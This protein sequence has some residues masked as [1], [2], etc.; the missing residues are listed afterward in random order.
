M[1]SR[2]K[3]LHYSRST[4]SKSHQELH[5]KPSPVLV[6]WPKARGV[7]PQYRE[8]STSDR[9]SSQPKFW[10]FWP[11]DS[12][13]QF[14]RDNCWVWLS[15]NRSSWAPLASAYFWSNQAIYSI[16]VLF[17]WIATSFV[18]GEGKISFPLHYFSIL[19][20]LFF[21]NRRETMTCMHVH[22][23][24]HAYC[25]CCWMSRERACKT[26]DLFLIFYNLNP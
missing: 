11:T 25:K 22:I 1:R 24:K 17:F 16:R 9:L 6:A 7:Y 14:R 4:A 19:I 8:S 26:C 12:S 23:R 13:I 10:S 5:S 20:L 21:K 2:N 15:W 18:R 3:L